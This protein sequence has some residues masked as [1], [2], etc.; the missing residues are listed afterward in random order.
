M[1]VDTLIDTRFRP[2]AY[3][4]RL[5]AKAIYVRKA[6]SRNTPFIKITKSVSCYASS[7]KVFPITLIEDS[8]NITNITA[9]LSQ[10][11]KYSRGK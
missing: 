2:Q 9:L 11:S 5:R 4:M 8:N 10:S 6:D 3:Q 1:N 7:A